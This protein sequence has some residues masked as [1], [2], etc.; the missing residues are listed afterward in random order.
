MGA[1]RCTFRLAL[2]APRQKSEY[3]VLRRSLGGHDC[4]RVCIQCA[5]H[6]G[7]PEQLL[8]DF[9]VGPNLLQHCRVGVTEGVP[10]NTLLQLDSPRRRRSATTDCNAAL[11]VTKMTMARAKN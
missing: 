1:K 2:T 8:H 9:D 11:G 10:S 5:S 3:S 4:L 6:R 7:M